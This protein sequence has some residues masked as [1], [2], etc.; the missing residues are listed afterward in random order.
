MQTITTK[1]LGATDT[2]GARFKATHT[3]DYTS[4][5]LGYDYA[6]SNEENHRA[7]AQ[8]LAEKLGWEGDY[9][10]GHTKAG[11]VFVN[12]APVCAFTTTREEV[13]A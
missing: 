13:A 11:M 6:L 3:G 1:Y 9:I 10:G 7:A 2:L 4:V 12:A 8:A 5:T